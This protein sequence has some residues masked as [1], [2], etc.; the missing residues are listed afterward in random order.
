MSEKCQ[1]RKLTVIAPSMQVLT[2]REFDPLKRA[3]RSFAM[4][5][6]VVSDGPICQTASE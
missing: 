2:E 6:H 3:R 5:R 1:K 4:C